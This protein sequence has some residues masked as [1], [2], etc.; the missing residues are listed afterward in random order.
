MPAHKVLNERDG[1]TALHWAA[2]F[3]LADGVTVL[4]EHGADVDAWIPDGWTA[5]HIAA[6]RGQAA[7]V[8]RLLEGGADVAARTTAGHTPRDLATRQAV[9][10]LLAQAADKAT[11]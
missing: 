3:G 5:L 10:R 8:T 4:L 1:W 9:I 2:R 6:Y 11:P 7:I